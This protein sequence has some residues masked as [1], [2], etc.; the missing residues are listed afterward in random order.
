MKIVFMGTPDFAAE[1]L[2]ALL[3]AGHDVALAVTQP[4]KPKG[5]GYEMTA[6]PV[7]RCAE[8]HG[9]P[10]AQPARVRENAEFLQ[11][12]RAAA[13][14]VIAVVA[15]GKILPQEILDL[16]RYGCINVHASLLPKY[17]GSAPIQWA[18]VRGETESGVTTMQM[19][20]G[21]D[22]GDML[23]Q[24]AV[25]I[26][27]DMTAEGLHDALASVGAQLLL[28]TLEALEKGALTPRKQDDA[29]A[30]Y[31]PMLRRQDGRLDFEKTVK[32]LCDQVRG[33]TPWP[34]AF[35]ALGDR[36][37]RVFSAAPAP[38]EGVPGTVLSADA[39]GLRIACRDGAVRF[40]ELQAT[41]GRRMTVEEYLRGHRI[42][43]GETAV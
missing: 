42:A 4:D 22:T 15:Y 29:Q 31:A 32:Q 23:L 37:F 20:A 14:D 21:M 24:R 36:T 7:K 33:F 26:P 10:V 43:A 2:E 3:A 9:V 13:P 6:S 40:G 30:T 28:E 38:G 39:D 35:F 16:P 34:G 11:T 41:G 1:S 27:P 5:R 19:D 12:L 25:P 8:A 17:R 18:I